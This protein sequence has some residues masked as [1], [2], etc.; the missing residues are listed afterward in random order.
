MRVCH[1]CCL[2]RDPYVRRPDLREEG[3]GAERAVIVERLIHDV[4]RVDLPAVVV[5]DL[6]DM[7]LHRPKQRITCTTVCCQLL[8]LKDQIQTVCYP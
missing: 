7:V 8:Q 5:H 1:P 4:P 6:R 2:K 3:R